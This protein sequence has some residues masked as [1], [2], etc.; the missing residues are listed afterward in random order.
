MTYGHYF[1][2][3]ALGQLVTSTCL[4]FLHLV[5]WLPV[6]VCY[7]CTWSVG[8]RFMFVFNRTQIEYNI[9]VTTETIFG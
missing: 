5:S 9:V 1:Y 8:Y 7:F 3:F 4:L 6:H 2:I